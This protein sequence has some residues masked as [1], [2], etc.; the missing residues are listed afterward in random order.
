MD[1]FH[2]FLEEKH[3][4]KRSSYHLSAV[5]TLLRKGA[6]SLWP[7]SMN[8]SLQ[9]VKNPFLGLTTLA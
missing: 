2:L 1:L 3:A 5:K 6:S 8:I 9:M 4:M 7:P